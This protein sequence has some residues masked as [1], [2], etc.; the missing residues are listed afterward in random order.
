MKNRTWLESFGHA[1][2]GIANTFKNERNF[3]IQIVL[4]IFAVIACIIFRVETWQF[5]LVS[6]AI[7][8]VLAMELVNT[9]VE[10][11]TDLYTNGE[12]H[13]LAK[14]A[15][16]AAAGAVLLASA[17]AIIAGIVIGVHIIMACTAIPVSHD[18]DGAETTNA[19]TAFFAT[20]SVDVKRNCCSR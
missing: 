2:D 4:G 12:M 5:V 16:D 6:F 17:F 1:F 18:T 3:R 14:R 7:L 9:A 19:S 8:F 20:G 11:L 10:A 13:P 15:K